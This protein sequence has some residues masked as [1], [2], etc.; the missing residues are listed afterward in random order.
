M[1]VV[2]DLVIKTI[3]Y[4]QC[5][6]SRLAMWQ[7]S[8]P[9]SQNSSLAHAHGCLSHARSCDKGL[10]KERI[11]NKSWRKT[12]PDNRLAPTFYKLSL[13]RC[14]HQHR[15]PVSETWALSIGI[16]SC[17]EIQRSVCTTSNRNQLAF[18][19]CCRFLK[20][21]VFVARHVRADLC[22]HFQETFSMRTARCW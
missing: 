19:R 4:I 15:L 14:L 18:C 2:L 16:T 6:Q 10:P 22:L 17:S 1:S 12:I 7:S 21:S 13:G 5:C 11:I 3:L 9:L 20:Q 8:V